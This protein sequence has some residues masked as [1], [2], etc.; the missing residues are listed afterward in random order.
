MMP[1]LQVQSLVPA[2]V[3]LVKLSLISLQLAV[4][5]RRFAWSVVIVSAHDIGTHVVYEVHFYELVPT[6]QG[7]FSWE[8]RDALRFFVGDRDSD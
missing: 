7:L 1:E 6:G 4:A 3:T 2:C 8:E 5:I